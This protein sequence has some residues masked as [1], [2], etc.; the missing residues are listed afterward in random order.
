MKFLFISRRLMDS[1]V[2]SFFGTVGA[3]AE[4][5]VQWVIGRRRNKRKISWESK[6]T[7]SALI[8]LIPLE[9]AFIAW[10]PMFI[11]CIA[12]VWRYA[13]RDILTLSLLMFD[14]LIGIRSMS[15]SGSNKRRA[16]NHSYH[17]FH[18]LPQVGSLKYKKQICRTKSTYR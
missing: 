6:T 2:F 3:L 17:I 7:L 5:R 14:K 11:T 4:R 9:R 8:L 18:P 15:L 16:F 13:S 1:H 10:L 12:H